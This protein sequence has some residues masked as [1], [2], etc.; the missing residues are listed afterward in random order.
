M[1]LTALSEH[2]IL[3]PG[4]KARAS[5]THVRAR[6]CVPPAQEAKDLK[7]DTSSS[8]SHRDRRDASFG[9]APSPKNSYIG[10]TINPTSNIPPTHT[11]THA[12]T[13]TH[14]HII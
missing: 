1:S 3:E 4:D 5:H 10:V 6:A 8:S 9:F 13:P 12:H 7:N 14:T 2:W 11:H